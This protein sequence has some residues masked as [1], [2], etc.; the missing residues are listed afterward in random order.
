MLATRNAWWH[1]GSRSTTTVC[2]EG[3]CAATD[4]EI[5]LQLVDLPTPPLVPT[6]AAFLASAAAGAASGAATAAAKFGRAAT[7]AAAAASSAVRLRP[8]PVVCAK[9]ARAAGPAGLAAAAAG[10]ACWSNHARSSAELCSTSP[11][12]AVH[13]SCLRGAL[14][15]AVRTSL[16]WS[17][18][19]LTRTICAR[20]SERPLKRSFSAIV[21]AHTSS[22]VALC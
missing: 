13:N 3:R 10:R 7:A 6:K 8:L 17:V 16:Y 5:C 19:S 1:C 22:C 12:G 11:V 9:V 20:G 15:E 14:V 4:A 2:L 18:Q 21:A